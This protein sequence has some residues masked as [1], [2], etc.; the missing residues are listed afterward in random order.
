MLLHILQ[1]RATQAVT[2]DARKDRFDIKSTREISQAPIADIPPPE[3]AFPAAPP[4]AAAVS[5]STPSRVSQ[6]SP[7]RSPAR[8]LHQQEGRILQ[9]KQLKQLQ[10]QQQQFALKELPSLPQQ[11]LSLQQEQQQTGNHADIIANATEQQLQTSPL[12]RPPRQQQR[13]NAVRQHLPTLDQSLQDPPVHAQQRKKVLQGLQDKYRH[14]H[15]QKQQAGQKVQQQQLPFQREQQQERGSLAAAVASCVTPGRRSLQA[16]H[17]GYLGQGQ[18]QQQQSTSLQAQQQQQQQQEQGSLAAVV[19]SCASPVEGGLQATLQGLLGQRQQQQQQQQE[20]HPQEE[21]QQ[22]Q[23]WQWLPQRSDAS[24]GLQDQ[25]QAQGHGAAADLVKQMKLLE[26]Q[27]QRRQQQQEAG[28]AS[29]IPSA[30]KHQMVSSTELSYTKALSAL[31]TALKA[32]PQSALGAGKE[33]EGG[34]VGVI[35]DGPPPTYEEL[36]ENERLKLQGSPSA[37]HLAV[38]ERARLRVVVDR[39]GRLADVKNQARAAYINREVSRK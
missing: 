15:H 21:Q 28:P 29:L 30:S 33:G 17:E 11:Q 35:S 10:Q 12:P 31:Q 9:T 38:N 5:A 23:H 27:M 8:Q 2:A 32:Q 24:V 39:W 1:D 37:V 34:R 16:T 18:R 4:P 19:A 6:N 22:Q 26:Q 7:K 36:M 14:R 20:Q 13:Q 25:Q 3:A